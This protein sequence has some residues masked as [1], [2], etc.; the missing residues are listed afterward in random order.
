MATWY[1]GGTYR[2]K[3]SITGSFIFPA[4]G[5]AI[6]Q[7]T[8][9]QYAIEV[10]PSDAWNYLAGAHWMVSKSWSLLGELGF[11]GSRQDVIIAAFY[12]F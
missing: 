4:A 11:G 10:E 1:A 7:N 8:S 9:L 6:G 3:M 5:T 12:R 2:V